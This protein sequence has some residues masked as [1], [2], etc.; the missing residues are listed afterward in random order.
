M[1][2]RYKSARISKPVPGITR[3][4]MAYS[5]SVMLTEHTL[6]KGAV[7]PEHSHIHEQL[8]YLVSGE[9]VLEINGELFQMAV[10]DSI[11]VP[12]NA[13]HKAT[14]VV[15]SVVLDIFTPAREDYL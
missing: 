2:S 8:V 7:L 14:A 9:L 4:V 5:P 1:I 15:P 3:R 6:E 10:G 11:V 13:V 12:S